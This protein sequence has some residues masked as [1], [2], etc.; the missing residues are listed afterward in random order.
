MQG[1]DAWKNGVKKATNWAQASQYPAVK[2]C[3]NVYDYMEGGDGK[4]NG[5]DYVFEFE[6]GDMHS[7]CWVVG[8]TGSCTNPSSANLYHLCACS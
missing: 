4:Y 8:A 2:P 7:K 1:K 5:A 3:D 6:P